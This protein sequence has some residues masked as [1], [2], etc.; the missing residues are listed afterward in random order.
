L[1]A[2]AMVV[3]HRPADQISYLQEILGRAI[4]A[5]VIVAQNGL[6]LEPGRIYLGE[7]GDHLTLLAGDVA[8]LIAGP[9]HEYRNRTVDLLFHSLAAH[10]GA[11]AIGVV[12][13]GCL[14]DGSRGL[15][16]IHDAR[17][18]T[19]VVTPSRHRTSGMPE[20]AIIYDGPIDVIGPS[21]VIA[22]AITGLVAARQ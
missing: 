22:S 19:M 9:R 13:S 21:A 11:S 8:G 20:N 17:G 3:L 18:T 5:A 4:P 1:A 7:P 16:A 10:A 12:L 6:A 14:D 15:A 2:V